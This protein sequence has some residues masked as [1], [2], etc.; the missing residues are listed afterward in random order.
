MKV[1]VDVTVNKPAEQVFDAMS[2][3]RNEPTWNSQVSKSELVSDE[4]IGMGTRFRTVNRGQE[5]DGVI[6]EYDRPQRLAFTVSG[7]AMTIQGSLAFADADG[8]TRVTGTFVLDPK[9]FMKVMLPLLGGMIR[10]DFPQ[11]FASFKAF[12][13]SR[14]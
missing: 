14:S 6:T 1:D 10:K 3:V 11:Q 4:P 9:G 2:D 7:R 5:Y 13:E 12:C 8:A